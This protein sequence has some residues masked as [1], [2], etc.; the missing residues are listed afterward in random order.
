MT[1]EGLRFGADG[2]IPV[3][4][5]D[6]GSGS[7]LTLA[8]ANREAVEKTIATRETHLWS[9]SRNK[10]WRKG[11]ESGNT[12]RV[13]AIDADCDGD[14]LVYRVVPAG[15]AC[16]TGAESCFHDAVLAAPEGERAGAFRAA[17]AH[18]EAVI[19][20][21]RGADPQKSYVAKLLAGGVDRIGKKIGEEATELV[22][23][24]K[25]RK[26]EEIVWEAADLMFHTLVLLAEEDVTLDEVGAE[27]K[28]RAN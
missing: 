15:P 27:F 14:A 28:R 9:R 8:Y 5:V 2:L 23:A 19:E 18:L 22:I 16:H 11:E 25:N 24:A 7:L 17:V 20:A 4:I 21:R 3:A 6:A 10:L 12:Q 26:R 13:V 1:L